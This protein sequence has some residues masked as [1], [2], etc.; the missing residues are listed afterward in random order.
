MRQPLCVHAESCR[1]LCPKL[2][3][4][5]LIK[6]YA[7]LG[8][9]GLDEPAKTMPRRGVDPLD[10]AKYILA[11]RS[12]L[13]GDTYFHISGFSVYKYD[14]PMRPEIKMSKK[15]IKRRMKTMSEMKDLDLT[16]LEEVLGGLSNGSLSQ[17]DTGAL[18]MIIRA[19]KLSGSTLEDLLNKMTDKK[20]SSESIK[21][22][23]DYVRAYWDHVQIQP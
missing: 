19:Y 6:T 14:R 17:T 18:N 2:Q 4:I 5:P 3:H 22:W 1:N 7:S 10:T 11:A 15:T 12:A 9:N 23:K 16:Q 8:L 21:E 13:D 20:G